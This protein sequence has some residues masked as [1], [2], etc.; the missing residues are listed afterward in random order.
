MIDRRTFLTAAPF[1][2]GLDR[3]PLQAQDPASPAWY[4]AALERM[5]ATRRLGVVLVVDPADPALGVR[6]ADCLQSGSA[7]EILGQAVL[8]TMIAPLARRHVL[9]GDEAVNRILLD[10]EGRRLAADRVAPEAFA[11]PVNFGLSFRPFVEGVDG[12]R[13]R[14]RAVETPEL[15]ELLANLDAEDART[16][17]A[18]E[19]ELVRLTDRHYP[20]LLWTSR[21]PGSAE[22]RGRIQ[23][24]LQGWTDAGRRLPFGAELRM[25][26]QVQIPAGD[27]CPTCGLGAVTEADARFLRF[28]ER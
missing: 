13:L 3:L 19:A 28:L 5:K 26:P 23:R 7:G 2:F 27:P 16:R 6:L 10:P 20:W 24:A 21:Q 25:Q 22:R 15:R 17:Q 12:A 11:N 1:V 14:E 9:Q 8:I 18:A 4:T